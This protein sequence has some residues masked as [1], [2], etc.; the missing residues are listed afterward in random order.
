MKRIV[1]VN[2][3]RVGILAVAILA[4]VSSAPAMQEQQGEQKKGRGKTAAQPTGTEGSLHIYAAKFAQA[5]DL[6]QKL[7]QLYPQS[8]FGGGRLGAI[9]FIADDRT[10]SVVI[11]AAEQREIDQ[12]VNLLK[13]LDEIAAKADK[14]EPQI[15]IYKLKNVEVDATLQKL[16]SLIAPNAVLDPR[17]QQVVAAGDERTLLQLDALLAQLDQER[18]RPAVGESQVRLIWLASGLENKDAPKPPADLKDVLAELKKIGID[19]V[20]LVSQ[21]LV[22]VSAGKVFN[23]QSPVMLDVPCHLT[24]SGQIVEK[25]GQAPTMDVK[26]HAMKTIVGARGTTSSVLCQLETEIAAPI[27]HSVVLGVTPMET[28]SSIFV[29]QMRR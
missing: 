7:S 8:Q 4:I 5:R 16:V 11:T 24:F 25:A 28:M 1:N 15:K 12:V 27:G 22:N 10:N 17:R 14:H 9:R 20:R 3:L 18:A 2:L 13:Q 23:V 26:V 19:D 29:L 21:S 6:A